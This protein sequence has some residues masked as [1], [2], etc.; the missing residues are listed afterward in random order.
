MESPLTEVTGGVGFS[1]VEAGT[2]EA[3]VKGEDCDV[4][5]TE[6]LVVLG[7]LGSMVLVAA[8]MK[9]KAEDAGPD[10]VVEAAGVRGKAL[11]VGGNPEKPKPEGC[12]GLA[13]MLAGAA[14][15]GGAL[16][17]AGDGD[18]KP[19][20]RLGLVLDDTGRLGLLTDGARLALGEK[21]SP[22]A[23]EDPKAGSDEGNFSVFS[24]LAGDIGS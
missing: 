21:E 16:V 2:K 20:P 19:N 12:T 18:P 11:V 9:E 6:T 1:T 22:G 5:E 14:E 17:G 8:W 7:R 23:A 10:E 4:P 15:T 24:G 13:G 3:T